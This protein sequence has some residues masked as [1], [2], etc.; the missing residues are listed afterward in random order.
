MTDSGE[1]EPFTEGED[2]DRCCALAAPHDGCCA[3]FCSGCGGA[4]RL[5]CFPDDLGCNCGF[6]DGHGYCAEC[7]GHGYF[8]DLGQPCCVS[9]GELVAYGTC[10][11]GGCDGAAERFRWST[12]TKGW[13][14]VCAAHIEPVGAT[15][16]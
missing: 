12:E 2:D 11:W 7:G 16:G 1:F 15:D 10:D 4:G 8:T 3:Y 5:N 9:V 13:L 14:P 6:C